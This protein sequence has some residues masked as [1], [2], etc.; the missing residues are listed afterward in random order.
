MGTFKLVKLIDPIQMHIDGTFNPLGAYN[1]ATDYAVGD[2]V[3][4]QGSSYIM[5]TN[6]AAGTVPTNTSYWGLVASKGDT[7]ATGATGDTGAA[8][9]DGEGVPIGGTTGQVLAKASNTNYD[10]EWS[11]AGAGDMAAAVYDPQ[12]IAGDAFARANHTGTQAISTVTNLQ[13]SLDGKVDE[14]AAITGATKTKI[15]YDAKGLVTAGADATQDDIGDGTTYKQYSA[16]DK[17][18][19]AGIE[20]AADVTDATNVAAAGAVMEADTSTA[21][22]SFVVDEDDMTSNSATKVPTQQ[23]VKAYVDTTVTGLLDFKGS[24]DTS[25]N[26]NYPAASKGDAYVV[27]VAGK[28]GGAS[29]KSVDIGDVYLATADNAGGTE[30]SVGT[31]WTVLEHNLVGALVS[32]NNLSDLASASTALTNLGLT[33]TATELNYTDGVTSA[34]QTQLDAKQ[35]LDADLTTIAGLTAT[36][37][38]FMQAKAG[39][40]ASRTVAQVKTDLG[41][42]GTNSGDQTITL[43]GDVTGSGTGSFATTLATVN[44]NTGSF[45]GTTAIPIITVNAKGLITAV[46]TAAV[47]GDAILKSITQTAHGLAVGDVVRFSGSGYIKAKADTAANA[48]A[49]GIVSA[50]ADANTFTLTVGGYVSTLSG[51]TADTVYF[52]SDA[53]DGLLDAAEPTSATSISKPV[54][55]SVST[56]AGYFY[57]F[58][59]NVVGSGASAGGDASTNTSTSVDSEVA[60]FSGTE[61]KTIKRATGSGIAKLTSGVLSVVT[62]PSGDI[63]GTTDT[64]AL[65]SKDLTA[66]TNTFPT[67]NQNTTGSAATLTTP[68]AIYGNNFDGSAAL[69]QIIASTYGGT[70]NGFTKFTGPTTAERTFTLPDASS[71][72]VVQGGALGTPSSGTLTNA[73]GLPV[74]GITA[75][76]STALGVGSVELGHATDTTLTRSSAGVLAVEGVV[77]PTV[78]STNTFTNKAITQRV[79][80]TTDDATAV[81]DV[82]VT[83]TYELSAVANATTFS[84]TGTPTDGQKLIIRFK[85][86]GVAKGLTWDAIFVAIGVTLPTTT[87]ASKWHYVGA[88]YNSAASKFH[89]LAVGQEA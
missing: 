61:G 21:S 80:T 24:T 79:V 81:I 71:T 18:K 16:T 48:E 10:T 6:A 87:V 78:S 82:A 14:N 4:Y 73:T 84:T 42:T 74:A 52:L 32:S 60:L 20:T 50:V 3:D 55:I 11:N 57:N 51:L 83:D 47:S 62:A 5:Y 37:D 67:F 22:M 86:A 64:Q 88:T 7:G 2:M 69:T 12:A 36:T 34:I 72:I 85:D 1:A 68:R 56:T 59:G 17:T 89:V 33:A 76:T 40:W 27:S 44:G 43:T 77:V 45:G 75:S 8:G 46:S 63:V 70:G 49:V 38:N 53:T 65:S 58:R 39:A 25:A 54:F 35:P 23:S 29:G 26:P 31:S 28:I 41:L 15:T 13:T 9:A 66:G 19:L 30:A